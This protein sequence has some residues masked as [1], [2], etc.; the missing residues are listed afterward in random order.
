MFFWHSVF[1]YHIPLHDVAVKLHSLSVDFWLF[2]LLPCKPFYVESLKFSQPWDLYSLRKEL[3]PKCWAECMM[4]IRSGTS[5]LL[6]GSWNL[7]THKEFSVHQKGV[8]T[9]SSTFCQAS[10]KPNGFP[11][12]IEVSE[13]DLLRCEM[14]FDNWIMKDSQC[15]HGECRRCL[16][17]DP[18]ATRQISETFKDSVL[19]FN[20]LFMKINYKNGNPRSFPQTQ[21]MPWKQE[22]F[23]SA[24]IGIGH[25]PRA[26]RIVATWEPDFQHGNHWPRHSQWLTKNPW[27]QL[28]QAAALKLALARL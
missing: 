5:D 19:A 3:W 11:L 26:F 6:M 18:S 20:W 16:K 4:W 27:H 23:S 24:M 8:L 7:Q 10:E 1:S 15:L 14:H 12:I 17:K 2:V 28:G 13:L 22:F 21:C 9:S 25:S